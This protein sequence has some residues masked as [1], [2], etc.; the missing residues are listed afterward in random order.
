MD[1]E[2]DWKTLRVDADIKIFRIRVDE[3]S[4]KKLRM[5]C[6]HLYVHVV[7]KTSNQFGDFTSLPSNVPQKDEQKCALQVQHDQFFFF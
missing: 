6:P 1:S 2:N 7:V 5:K 3:A 4:E